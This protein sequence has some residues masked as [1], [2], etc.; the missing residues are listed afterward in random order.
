MQTTHHLGPSKLKY[1]G[2]KQTE[3]K[4]LS[5]TETQ[6]LEE[7]AMTF[8]ISPKTTRYPLTP[9]ETYW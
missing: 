7:G 8:N 4:L 5:L 6:T 1:K 9:A 3:T 2:S